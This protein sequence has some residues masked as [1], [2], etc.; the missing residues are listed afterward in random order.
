MAEIFAVGNLLALSGEI[1]NFP[2]TLRIIKP[3]ELGTIVLSGSPKHVT[4]VCPDERLIGAARVTEALRMSFRVAQK[5][6]S[7]A[8]I[9]LVSELVDVDDLAVD[10]F[11]QHEKGT[12]LRLPSP[13][14]LTAHKAK[15]SPGSYAH[16]LDV[17][18]NFVPTEVSVYEPLLSQDH[19]KVLDLGS[20]VGKNARVMARQRHSVTAIDASAWAVARSRVFVPEVR[21]LVASAAYL[22]FQ[23]ASF[24]AVV[25][26]GCLHCMR[27]EDRAN[28]VR[29]VARVLKPGGRLYSRIF[30]PQSPEWVERQP[31]EAE[32]F[33]MSEAE[34][35]SLL[36]NV[37]PDL[38]WRRE[39]PDAHYLTATLNDGVK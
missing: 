22:P 39:D 11:V 20:G 37:F 8:S 30:R 32:E 19:L 7:Q 26:V 27:T 3:Q 10:G 28:A 23:D 15:E 29:E 13:L 5:S 16:V 9:S 38:E 17:H 21:A 18:W 25:D 31:F 2:S 35:R 6:W 14:A 33:G 12:F 1:G 34:V 24:D 36:G 4:I